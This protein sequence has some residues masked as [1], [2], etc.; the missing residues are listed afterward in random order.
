M[1]GATFVDT[2]IVIIIVVE[3]VTGIKDTVK[4][5]RGCSGRDGAMYAVPSL[6]LARDVHAALVWHSGG[7]V[8]VMICLCQV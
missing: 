4:L 6:L 1:V 8:F 3:F 5:R 2:L 7:V